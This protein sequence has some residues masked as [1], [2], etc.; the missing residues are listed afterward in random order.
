MRIVEEEGEEEEASSPS[1]TNPKRHSLQ[2][3]LQPTARYMD[4]CASHPKSLSH[5]VGCKG[6]A[7]ASTRRHHASRS[8]DMHT[9][10]ARTRELARYVMRRRTRKPASRSPARTATA[11]RPGDRANRGGQ[12]VVLR[13]KKRSTGDKSTN[14]SA[15]AGDEH[16]AWRKEEGKLELKLD[17]RTSCAACP[18][19]TFSALGGR[20]SGWGKCFGLSHVTRHRTLARACRQQGTEDILSMDLAQRQRLCRSSS[21]LQ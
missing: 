9:S 4:V 5:G 18:T 15:T 8:L 20:S 11:S 17:G 2:P 12:L 19:E 1:Q 3:M 14:A 6:N 10:P 21:E 16:R 13:C 7:Y